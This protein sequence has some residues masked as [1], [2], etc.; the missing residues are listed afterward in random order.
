MTHGALYQADLAETPLPEALRNIGALRTSGV[1]EARVDDVVKRLALRDGYVVHA[2]SSVPEDW[3]GSYLYRQGRISESEH[4]AIGERSRFS[5]KVG[6]L[7]VERGLLQPPEILA[8]IRQHTEAIVWSLFSWSRGKVEFRG[9]SLGSLT[10][11]VLIQMPLARLI[12]EG[13]RRVPDP[14]PLLQRLG[15]RDARLEPS[16]RTE[17]LIA[18][19]L[20]PDERRILENVDG[21]RSL[22]E[23]CSMGPLQPADTARLLFS[24]RVL[25][26]VRPSVAASQKNGPIKIRLRTAGDE[27]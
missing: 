8:A 9:A 27:L 17:D 19:G 15:G 14:R 6:V 3:L 21:R 18:A 26:L 1:V 7:L 24:F 25:D 5:K 22:V 2:A 11:R 16:F 13:S 4:A 12:V 23:L 10:G 20:E